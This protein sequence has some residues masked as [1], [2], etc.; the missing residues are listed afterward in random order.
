MATCP[1]CG[2]KLKLTDWKPNCPKCGVNLVYYNMDERL[3]EEADIAELDHVRVQKKIDRLKAS[4][5]GSKLAA[6]R[7]ALL[8]IGAVGDHDA[9]CD[10][11]A[12]S[13]ERNLQ[14]AVH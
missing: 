7:L 5:V 10:A 3:Q 12:A 8:I 1:N 13:C 14:R 4:F 9:H 2:H 11:Y 6:V